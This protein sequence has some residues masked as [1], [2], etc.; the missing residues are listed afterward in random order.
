M[1]RT[2]ALLTAS[3]LSLALLG[4]CD[5]D[6]EAKTD[7]KTETEKEKPAPKKEMAELFPTKS[8]ELPP[9]LAGLEFGMTEA[10]AEKVLK[11][12]SNLSLIHI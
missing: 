7:A 1:T 5:K 12:I 6:G 8:V 2:H 11:G 10:A 4:G 9:P 3:F